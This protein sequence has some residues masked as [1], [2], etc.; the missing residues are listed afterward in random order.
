VLGDT[1]ERTHLKGHS[2]NLKVTFV[3]GKQTDAQLGQFDRIST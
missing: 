2:A 1:L 3:Y